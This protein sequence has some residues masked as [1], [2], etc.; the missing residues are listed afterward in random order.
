LLVVVW[1]RFLIPWC[2][3]ALAAWVLFGPIPAAAGPPDGTL[4]VTFQDSASQA[5]AEQLLQASGARIVEQLKPLAVYRVAA[6][7]DD[8]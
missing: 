8:A 1:R 6:P 7:E 5:A 2:A 4:L 3:F